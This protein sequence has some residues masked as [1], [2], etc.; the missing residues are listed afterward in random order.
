MSEWH[1]LCYLIHKRPF[2][3]YHSWV[4]LLTKEHGVVSAC[5][6]ESKKSR[7]GYEPLMTFG[8]YWCH[9]RLTQ[10]L[11]LNKIETYCQPYNLSGLAAVSGMYIN[12]LLY[13]TCKDTSLSDTF[14][15][16]ARMLPGL[17]L[18]GQELIIALRCFELVLLKDLGYA[19]A[20]EQ[21]LS[22]HYEHF[23]YNFGIGLIGTAD[24]TK[25]SFPRQHI[26]AIVDGDW[27]L[28][29]VLSSAKR[30]NRL[31]ISYVL[32]GKVLQCYSWF[33]EG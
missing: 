13:N 21:A 4:W 3:D 7:K 15:A 5:V 22:S 18:G 2:K 9:G 25:F 32:E 6:R 19:F 26:Q 29:G 27:L 11:N 14:S 17:A 10:V 28:P 33:Q 8:C 23:H 1:D 30:L 24:V 31:A 16:Y 12:E 20:F